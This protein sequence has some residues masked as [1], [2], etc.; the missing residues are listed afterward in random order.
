[1]KIDELTNRAVQAESHEE[2]LKERNKSLLE[3]YKVVSQK[4]AKVEAGGGTSVSLVRA[5]NAKNPPAVYVK[6]SITNVLKES[7]LVE[8]NVGSD[9]GVKEGNTLEVYRLKPK[10]EY[11]G[12]LKILDAY[13]RKAVGRMLKSDGGMRRSAVIKGDEVASKIMAR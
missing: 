7:G 2:I 6:G 1:K 4:L 11:L 13:H 10:P 12:T 3:Q 8:V 9:D 5:S